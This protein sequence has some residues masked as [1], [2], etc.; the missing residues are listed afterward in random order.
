V[1]DWPDD[2]PLR[3]RVTIRTTLT[4]GDRK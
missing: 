1:D 4:N 2:P 3:N